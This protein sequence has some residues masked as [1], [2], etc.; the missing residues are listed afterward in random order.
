MPG[1]GTD[2]ARDPG[3]FRNSSV[4]I[5]CCMVLGALIGGMQSRQDGLWGPSRM[6]GVGIWGDKCIHLKPAEMREEAG[7]RVLSQ[8]WSLSLSSVIILFVPFHSRTPGH[9]SFSFPPRPQCLSISV[10]VS[11]S[12]SL[13][14]YLCFCLTALL[15]LAYDLKFIVQPKLALNSSSCFRNLSGFW[16][17]SW[18]PSRGT[19]AAFLSVC[20]SPIRSGSV[21][22]L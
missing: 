16:D 5:I 4:Y 6:L 9:W 13:S 12:L 22:S 7:G 21:F 2:G 15:R 14:F 18:A 20:L 1:S 11:L 19:L 10:S 8:H 3:N 17:C